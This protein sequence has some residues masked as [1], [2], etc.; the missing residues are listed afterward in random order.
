M[1][2]YWSVSGRLCELA[3]EDV[4]A[5]FHGLGLLLVRDWGSPGRPLK[6]CGDDDGGYWRPRSVWQVSD[7]LKFAQV[8]GFQPR[9]GYMLAG[10]YN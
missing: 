10:E 6:V 8:T 3:F 9:T 4:T 7:R 1:T 2:A 5:L